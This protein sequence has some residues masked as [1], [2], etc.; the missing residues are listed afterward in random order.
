MNSLQRR[1]LTLVPIKIFHLWRFS[2]IHIDSNPAIFLHLSLHTDKNRNDVIF[3][4]KALF[5]FKHCK[6]SSRLIFLSCR[7][8]VLME[9]HRS[10]EFSYTYF[11][12]F[13]FL[14][15]LIFNFVIEI[16]SLIFIFISQFKI[17]LL[18]TNLCTPI[19]GTLRHCDGCVNICVFMS[20]VI[21]GGLR[22]VY[23]SD[24]IQR[25][26]NQRILV[27]CKYSRR[28]LFYRPNQM[29]ARPKRT[30]QRSLQDGLLSWHTFDKFV[31]LQFRELACPIPS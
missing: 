8:Y 11:S 9:R 4:H 24:C 19:L 5:F 6:F 29:I 12:L 31:A 17:F 21:C 26:S 3:P 28:K 13:F 16:F 10:Y 18:T 27:D 25:C 1:K 30:R 23:R 20:V 22:R 7:I 14:S 2:P 15:W